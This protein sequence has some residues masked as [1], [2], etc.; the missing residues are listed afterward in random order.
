MANIISFKT[1]DEIAQD[2]A[3][4][5]AAQRLAQNLT[6]QDVYQRAGIAGSTFKKF[7]QTGESSLQRFIAILRAIGRLDVLAQILNTQPQISPMQ[8]LTGK[9]VVQRKRARKK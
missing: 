1:D 5:V 6:Q 2:L 9:N 7:E 8:R 3:S 4:W